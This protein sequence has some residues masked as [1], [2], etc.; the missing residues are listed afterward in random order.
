M[1]EIKQRA[2]CWWVLTTTAGDCI[3]LKGR[4]GSRPQTGGRIMQHEGH[5]DAVGA[6]EA[7]IESAVTSSRTL[8]DLREN[9]EELLILD[10]GRK[11][12]NEAVR[13]FVETRQ[14]M[15]DALAA[16]AWA[17]GAY[18]EGAEYMGSQHPDKIY[19]AAV[20]AVVEKKIGED[21][22]LRRDLAL[23]TLTRAAEEVAKSGHYQ[24][25]ATEDQEDKLRRYVAF[26]RAVYCFLRDGLL[27][28]LGVSDDITLTD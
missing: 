16:A 24:G 25:R 13:R 21:T 17:Q 11:A 26:T 20:I 22:E 28:N 9:Y 3:M 15:A 18:S 8:D 2:A 10:H 27:L 14:A 19:P 6:M 23:V 1:N 12:W 7:A 5:P 4:E